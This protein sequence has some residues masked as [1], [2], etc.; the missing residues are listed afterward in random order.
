MALI[1]GP[2][3]GSIIDL[4]FDISTW[5]ILLGKPQFGRQNDRKLKNH[6]GL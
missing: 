1:A 4:H 5:V 3:A 2:L 6:M